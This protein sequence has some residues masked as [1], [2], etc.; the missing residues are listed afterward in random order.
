MRPASVLLALL[1][2]ACGG[3]SDPAELTNSGYKNLSAADFGAAID[4]FDRAL[5]AIGEDPANPLYLRAKM[6]AIGAHTEADPARARTDFL[7][8]S[9]ALPDSVSDR[10]FSRV[11]GRLGDAGHFKDAVALLEK[12][13]AAHP[14]STALDALGKQLAAQANQADDPA[15][16]EALRGLGYVGE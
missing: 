5:A 8:L 13:K 2:T 10:D 3:S 4:D 14:D 11:A 16:V 7:A 15:A 12:G 6:G 1:L 9:E